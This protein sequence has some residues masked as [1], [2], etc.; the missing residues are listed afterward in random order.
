MADSETNDSPKDIVYRFVAGLCMGA[1]DVVP[2]VSG[3]TIAFVLGVYDRLIQAIRSI[4]MVLIRKALR[5]DIKGV[6]AHVDWKFLLPLGMGIVVS[7]LSLA[8]GVGWALEQTQQR[9]FAV[10]R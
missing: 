3:G 6:F 4:N 7:L 1:A 10:N 9:G 2:G 8:H 5:F